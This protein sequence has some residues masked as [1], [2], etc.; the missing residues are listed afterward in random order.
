MRCC[1][2]VLGHV[3]HSPPEDTLVD[4]WLC[5]LSTMTATFDFG[6]GRNPVANRDRILANRHNS[7][8][9]HFNGHFP[10][11]PGLASARMSPFWILL[12]Q[13]M[14]ELVV[15]TGAKMCKAPVKSSLP[16]NQQP[17]FYRPDALPVTKPTVS[18]HWRETNR[19]NLRNH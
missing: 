4:D 18:K 7:L 1:S 15:T 13:R 5:M 2:F 6:S 19:H 16:T 11:G 9:F 14:M 17:L 8:S 10:G 12:E 3:Q